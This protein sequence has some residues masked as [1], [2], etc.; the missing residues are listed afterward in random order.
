MLDI[1][2]IRNDPAAM[3]AKLAKKGCQVDFSEFLSNDQRR[4]ELIVQVEGLKAKKNQQSAL[5][6]QLKKEGK[7]V[8]AIF[9]EMKAVSEKTRILDEQL[10][11]IDEMQKTFLDALPN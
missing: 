9:V 7:D 6:P 5:I 2:L 1:N 4:R 3:Q 11:A 8:S 10:A